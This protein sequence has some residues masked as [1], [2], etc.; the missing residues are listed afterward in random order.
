MS[1]SRS[2]PARRRARIVAG[3]LLVAG[4][5]LGVTPLDSALAGDPSQWG[6]KVNEYEGQHRGAGRPD[7]GQHHGHGQQGDADRR[8][9]EY[10]GQH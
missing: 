9:N 6:R 3:S 8:V 10:E 7:A 2:N 4:T 1:I 5:L